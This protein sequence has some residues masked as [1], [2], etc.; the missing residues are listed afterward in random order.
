MSHVSW[1][2]ADVTIAQLGD[3]YSIAWSQSAE[4]LGWTPNIMHN[5][6]QR[7]LN[8]IVYQ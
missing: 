7:I 3:H 6:M 5:H 2:L 1:L 4:F 8:L